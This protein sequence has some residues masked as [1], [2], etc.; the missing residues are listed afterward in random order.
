MGAFGGLVAVTALPAFAS[1]TSAPYTIGAPSGTVTNVAI[2]P[3][4]ATT[5]VAQSYQV[6]FT[7][8]AALAES[9]TAADDG[10]ITITPSTAWAGTGDVPTTVELIDTTSGCFQ[11]GVT[12][13]GASAASVDATTGI[14]IALANSCPSI[15]S[16]QTVDV[17]FSVATNAGFSVTVGTSAN[18]TSSAS[19]SVA[20]SS[21]PPAVAENSQSFGYP[22]TYTFT[23]VGAAGAACAAG[24]VTCTWSGLSTTVSAIVITSKGTA[25]ADAVA[26][27]TSGAFTVSYTSGTT[28]TSDTVTSAFTTTTEPNDTVTLVLGTPVAVG[29]TF[30]IT[31]QGTNPPAASSDV[32]DIEP[33]K[34][35]GPS[36]GD[37]NTA[38]VVIPTEV[39]SAVSYGTSVQDGTVAA[40][41]AVAGAPATYTVSFKATSGAAGT[42]YIGLEESAGPTTFSSVTGILV[43]DTNANWFFVPNAVTTTAVVGTPTVSGNTPVAAPS[44]SGGVDDILAIPLDGMTVTAGD[45]LTIS[46]VGVTN[47]SSNQ[48]VSDF[49]V[50]TSGDTVTAPVATYTIGASGAA[51]P[52][53]TPAS[54]AVSATTNYTI[55]N[56]YA[57]STLAGSTSDSLTLTAEA[58][59]VLPDSASF[60]TFTDNTTAAG[61]GTAAGLTGYTPTTA[62]LTVPNADIVSGDLLT[63]SIADVVNPSGAGSY[64]ITFGSSVTGPSVI[65]PFPQADVTYPNGSIIDFSGTDY[66][67]AGGHAFG[68]ATPTLLAKLQSVDHATVVKAAAGAILP[69]TAPRAGTLITTS[70]VNGN[71][72][73]Y[74]VGTDGELH[75]FVTSASFLSDGYDPALTVTVPM[76]GG[77][78][79]GSTASVEGTAITALAT[80]ADGAIV[81][82][83]GTYYVYDGGKAFGIPT[84]TWLSAVRKTDTATPLTGTISSSQTGAG[85]AS[86]VLLTQNGIVYVSYVGDVFPFKSETQLSADGYAGTAAVTLPNLGGLSVVTG[87]SGS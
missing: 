58:G 56:L 4:T 64:T 53:V 83:S 86:G 21:V 85:I 13:A 33:L 37:N 14:T 29:D 52:V 75:G 54:D 11:S 10:T 5:G 80:A 79:T 32:F 60:Y 28:T 77:L 69:T 1:V 18:S 76:L 67:F 55:T 68:I 57:A 15:A 6:S 36:V 3:T 22:A 70:T 44:T 41:P 46:L 81:D 16:G 45:S 47:P 9:T 84:P 38:S 35:T 17:D 51:L 23:S 40:S 26:W 30:T 27:D 78:T 59:T 7:S 50:W 25:T 87:Y 73:I 66:L 31:A 82:S 19:A 20:V 43:K 74:A 2:S 72:T 65:A 62:T 42:G 39:T 48:S 8:T 34:S 63:L 61:S 24:G 12:G 49:D 71:A